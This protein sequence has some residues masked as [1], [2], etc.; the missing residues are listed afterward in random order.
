MKK[1]EKKRQQFQMKSETHWKILTEKK[2][3]RRENQFMSTT[4]PHTHLSL[5]LK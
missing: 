4:F 2:Q 1:E 5:L 3:R